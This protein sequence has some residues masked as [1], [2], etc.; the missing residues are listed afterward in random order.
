MNCFILPSFF[1]SPFQNKLWYLNIFERIFIHPTTTTPLKSSKKLI[2]FACKLHVIVWMENSRDKR[3]YCSLK[4]MTDYCKRSEEGKKEGWLCE[5]RK[6]GA[7]IQSSSADRNKAHTRLKREI[8]LNTSVE[9]KIWKN[10]S[11][12]AR[13]KEQFENYLS[14]AAKY[15]KRRKFGALNSH[16]KLTLFFFLPN[17][18]LKYFW[19]S[20]SVPAWNNEIFSRNFR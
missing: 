10:V 17:T 8:Y 2:L 16:E 7:K 3:T 14:T 9:K 4:K 19:F 12:Y 1:C 11:L 18:S 20:S 6:K 13:K 5:Q 15:E